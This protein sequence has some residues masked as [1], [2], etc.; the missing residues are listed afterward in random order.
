[1]ATLRGFPAVAE[2]YG[3]DEAFLGVRTE[4]PHMFA[5]AVRA[6]VLDETGL[7]SS[8]GIGDTKQRA[9]LATGFAKPAGIY[10]LTEDNWVTVMAKAPDGGALGDRPQ[11]R[12]EAVRR[13]HRHCCAA[14]C[15]RLRRP[16]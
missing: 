14:G 9:K 13:R 8:V 15:G 4:D 5:V 12:R 1:M 7:S 3:W 10:R 2:V 16:G 6:A 11:D